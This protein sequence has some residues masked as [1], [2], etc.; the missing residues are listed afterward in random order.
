MK[1]KN[2]Y[3]IQISLCTILIK[4]S[5][6]FSV[7]GQ[8]DKEA[9]IDALLAKMSVEEKVGQMTQVDLNVIA[10]GGYS[11]K[12][13]KLDK[14]LLETAVTKYFIGSVLNPVGRAYT[15]ETWH[16]II[17]E[18][19]DVSLKKSPN[20]IPVIY[21]IDAVH[22]TTFTLEATL[23]PHN[24]GLA[25]TRNEALVKQAAKVTAMEVRASGIRWN[26]SP[27]L[28]LGRQPLWS[29]FP[30]TW[31]E[32][33]YITKV[34][35]AASVKGMEEDGLKN[36]T[37]VASCMKH[38]V[39]YSAPRSGKDRT[40]AYI[41]DIVLRE[42]Y[43]PQFK[44]AV[45]SGASTV[46]INSAEING[47]PT[48]ANA[49][50]LKEVLRKELGFKG[51]IVTDWEDIIRLHTRHKI[52][53]S[54]E[55]AVKIAIN[56][57][58]DMS[59]V[60]NDYSF[61]TI[62]TQL[63]KK[64]EISVSRLDESVRRILRLKFDLG[65]FDN[66][67][68]EKNAHVNFK[69]PQFQQLA[70]DAARES[71]TLLKNDLKKDSVNHFLP[72]A[73]N[74]KVLVTGPAAANVTCLHGCWSYTWQ[75]T[76]KSYYPSGIKSVKSAI[77]DK[78]GKSNV[79]SV[80]QTSFEGA[81]DYKLDSVKIKAAGADVIVLCLGEEAYAESP[82]AVDD[83]T[84]PEEQLELARVAAATGKPVILVLSQGR[85]RVISKIV[86]QMKGILLAYWSG[87]K[88][89]EAISDVLFGDYN[90]DG[91]LPFSY[92]AATGDIVHYD[93]KFS[94]KIQ[95]SMK[96][97]TYNGYKPQWEFG[98]GLSYTTFVY[99][100]L[101]VSKTT[102]AGDEKISV[103]VTVKNTG[104]TAGKHVVELYSRDL[105]ATITPCEKRLRKF[106][107]LLLA[108]GESK[109][110]MFE[111]DRHDLAFVNNQLLTVTEPG[112]FELIAGDK[113]VM[114]NFK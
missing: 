39:G 94:E 98:H 6:L 82:G 20:K 74:M 87:N 17:T 56:A 24:I 37:A 102:F 62:L 48:H 95:E 77:E 44:A 100:D 34:M 11:N 2:F 93:H 70:L 79:L 92:P 8:S 91:R 45:E 108:P 88:G 57:G 14:A 114:V 51:L 9:R 25:A 13:G 59:M 35:G 63:V 72:L 111:L 85:P 67:Y 29:R 103:T 96:G 49:Y 54:P 31:G 66:P 90:P 1:R 81:G 12:D 27:V 101:K 16:K 7:Y 89:A 26:F 52:A 106:E 110:V 97:F 41:P 104:K 21:G 64:N 58:I 107:K 69:K 4:I 61:H 71:I 19:Q 75:G 36:P 109:E 18:I 68:P 22:G 46:M 55:E 86:P 112:E 105:F 28:D 113:K 65:L 3:L 15:T 50:L 73:K 43:L 47:T 40:P 53:A 33:V 76:D 80:L 84:L 60:P 83:L 23:F 42:Y 38:F 32:D 99:S 30:E 5:V 10:A 78:I